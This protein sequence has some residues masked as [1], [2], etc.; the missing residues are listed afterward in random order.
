M[1]TELIA[2]NIC[3]FD[4]CKKAGKWTLAE[5]TDLPS[6]LICSLNHFEFYVSILARLISRFMTRKNSS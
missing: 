5:Q 4:R 6:P 3:L 2:R 1:L